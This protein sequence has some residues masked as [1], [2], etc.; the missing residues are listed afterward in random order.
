MDFMRTPT[1]GF[2]GET[3]VLTQTGY[4]PIRDLSVGD[5]V[6]TEEG[7]V[8]TISQIQQYQRIACKETA[9]YLIPKG[10]L[11]T[12]Q[13]IYAAPL[14]RISLGRGGKRVQ[15]SAI[16]GPVVQ[17]E[18]DSSSEIVYYNVRLTSKEENM[19]LV[20]GIAVEPIPAND[21]TEITSEEFRDL[22]FERYGDRPSDD[23]IKAIFKICRKLP[24]GKMEVPLFL[25]N[26]DL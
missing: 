17:R 20:S 3:P 2:L 8:D 4:R 6:I 23:T 16:G 1:T 21:R 14:Q 11:S 18:Y 24:D 26:N 9:P 25:L 13:T 10:V 15:V 7:S 19:I 12:R 5:K 22:M